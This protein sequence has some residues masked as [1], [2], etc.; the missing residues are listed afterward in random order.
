ML[1]AVFQSHGDTAG[2]VL[3]TVL[4]N[5]DHGY[6]GAVATHRHPFSI[7]D[8]EAFSMNMIWLGVWRRGE[9]QFYY[10]QD[11]RDAAVMRQKTAP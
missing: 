5:L 10:P 7:S 6:A 2:P 4:E 9:V 11:A 1:R 8:H 3:K